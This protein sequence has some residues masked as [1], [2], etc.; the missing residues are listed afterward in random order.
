MQTNPYILFNGNC[1]E[2]FKFYERALGAKIECVLT[3][4]GTPAEA[5]VAP[6]FRKKVMHGRINLNG[7]T[8]MGSDCPPDRY[9][10]PQ[11]FSITLTVQDAGQAERLYHALEDGGHVGMPIQET[12]W[13][14]RFGML[15]DR[16][17]IP[18]MINCEKAQMDTTRMEECTAAVR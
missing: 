4:E 18:W 10:K 11:G 7:Q 5:H 2:A 9:Q 12:F 8:I 6:E 13:A 3:H 14:V 17:G 15:T 16:F 1:E